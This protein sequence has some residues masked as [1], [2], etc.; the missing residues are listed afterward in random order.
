MLV[1]AQLLRVVEPF[2]VGV[3]VLVIIVVRVESILI[4]IV[5]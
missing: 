3:V 1:V 2:V 4:V 5:V